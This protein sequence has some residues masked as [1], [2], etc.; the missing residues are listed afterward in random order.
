MKKTTA[1]CLVICLVLSMFLSSALAA[2]PYEEEVKPNAVMLLDAATGQVLYEKNADEQIY[3]AST[4]KILTCI[5]A[6]EKGNLDDMVTIGEDGDWTG[7]GYSLMGLKKGQKISLRELIYGMMLISGNDAAAAIAVHLG[8]SIEGFADMMNQKAQELGMTGSHFLTPHGVDTD[9]HYVTARDMATLSL[10]AMKNEQFMEIVGS[11]SYEFPSMNFTE[12]KQKQNTNKLLISDVP[13]GETNYYYEYTTGIK[14]GATPKAYR[15][16]VSSAEKDGMKLLCLIYGDETG[17]GTQRWPLAK[18]LFEYGFNTYETVDIKSLIA[19]VPVSVNV[20]NASPDDSQ[21]GALT[22]NAAYEG[23]D[24]VTMDKEKAEAI[25]S[26]GLTAQVALASGETLQAPVKM[27]DSVGTVKYVDANGETVAEAPLTASR[28]VYVDAG[29]INEP[30]DVT[31]AEPT[32]PQTQTA[33][34]GIGSWIWYA[35]GGVLLVLAVIFVVGLTRAY[36]QRKKRRKRNYAQRRPATRS[37]R[38]SS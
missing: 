34:P 37:G 16:L 11:S 28:D 23:V 38:R 22:L 24:L 20:A 3:P 2:A 30:Q 4:T 10:Y 32:L 35:A 18:S 27:G 1:V 31:S 33:S 8:G 15:C 17:D 14:T 26:G 5:L 13:E 29:I 19:N 36:N 7:S 25:K 12:E 21:G 6:L 9:G